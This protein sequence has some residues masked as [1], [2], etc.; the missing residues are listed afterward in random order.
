MSRKPR[1]FR[2]RK[3]ADRSDDHYLRWFHSAGESDCIR[4]DPA[5]NRTE[6]PLRSTPP[7]LISS[8]YDAP[9]VSRFQL[10]TLARYHFVTDDFPMI[11]DPNV[12]ATSVMQTFNIGNT[13][14]DLHVGQLVGDLHGAA[15]VADL[16][17]ECFRRVVQSG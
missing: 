12:G 3:A 8:F 14:D 16:Q 6:L 9:T 15:A 7:S 11:D 10:A 17:H 2:P 13:S 4:A 1:G 5:A